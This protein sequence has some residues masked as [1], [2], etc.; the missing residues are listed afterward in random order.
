M[1]QIIFV[2]SPYRGD[3]EKNTNRA[4]CYCRFVV[5]KGFIPI[6]PHLLFPQF[7]NDNLSKERNQAIQMNLGILRKCS[8]LWAFGRETTIGMWQEI[9]AAKE[10]GIPVRY[11]AEAEVTECC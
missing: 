3:A 6:A 9:K 1:E 5:D 4:R 8:E 2:C 7:M 10:F 11:I